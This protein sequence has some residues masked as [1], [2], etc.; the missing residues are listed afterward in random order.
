MRPD[1][2]DKMRHQCR[3]HSSSTV[4]SDEVQFQAARLR[5]ATHLAKRWFQAGR[6]SMVKWTPSSRFSFNSR[7]SAGS[8]LNSSGSLS[9]APG[10]GA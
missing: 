9:I 1:V 8:P 10:S 7:L 5:R 6:D 2:P 3:L 4:G